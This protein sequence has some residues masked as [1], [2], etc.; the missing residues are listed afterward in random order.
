MNREYL[1]VIPTR[2]R[3][4]LVIRAI[5]SAFT[6]SVTPA[7]V[8]V[9]DDASTDKRYEWIEDII[10]HPRLTVIRREVSSQDLTG[11][12]FAVGTVR[13]AGLEYARR[14]RFDGWIAFLDDDDEWMPSKMDIQ[15]DAASRYEQVQAFCSNALNRDP[16]GRVC[17]YHH[18]PHGRKL[19][20]NYMDVT[21]VVRDFNP[22]I[23]STGI[24]DA[25]VASRVGLQ[26]PYG[27]GEDWDYWRRV[28][29]LSPI[30]RV[31]EPLAY[32]TIGNSKEYRL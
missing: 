16:F 6:Q 23:N 29:I 5:R 31:D 1:V 25:T 26:N 11:H 21:S 27:F 22:V 8:V 4:D 17:G 7:E 2:N 14:I 9:V 28:A 18:E 15:F 3:Y 19:S 32:Y 12:G 13:N 10:N 24:V 20:S 30:I